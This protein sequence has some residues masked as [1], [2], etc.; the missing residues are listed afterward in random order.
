[1][2]EAVNSVLSNASILRNTSEGINS[3]SASANVKIGDIGQSQSIERVV[4]QLPQFISPYVSTDGGYSNTVIQ[5]R[6]SNTGDVLSQFPTQLRASIA[7]AAQTAPA[8]VDNAPSIEVRQLQSS[9]AQILIQQQSVD[10][11]NLTPKTQ[12]ATPEAQAAITAL[13]TAAQ[14]TAAPTA[15]DVGFSA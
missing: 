14:S 13:S 8:S 11:Q 6:D 1:M 7:V 3:A 5:V 9:Q 12:I 4:A 15:S 2:I 10:T